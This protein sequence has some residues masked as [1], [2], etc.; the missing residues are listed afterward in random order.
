M[1]WRVNVEVLDLNRRICHQIPM[2]EPDGRKC[3]DS[4]YYEVECS[5]ERGRMTDTFET[6]F[7]VTELMCDT[8]ASGSPVQAWN[9]ADAYIL[10]KIHDDYGAALADKKLAIVN[11]QFGALTCALH[12]FNPEVYS[13]SAIF[14]RWLKI[15]RQGQDTD[16]Q[17]IESI[18]E[19]N[20]DLFLVKLPKNLHF[21]QHLLSLISGVREAVVYVSGMQKYWPKSFFQTSG[22][23]FP[24]MT[25]FPGIKKA[26]CMRLSGVQNTP[27]VDLTHLV[28]MEDFG[29]SCVNYPNVFSREQLD[30][31]A[32]FF[33]ENAPALTSAQRVMDLACGNGVLGIQALMRH[34]DCNVHFIDESDYA[35]R[36][37]E[38]SLAYNQIRAERATLHQNDCL[39]DL[40][41]H[42]FDAILCNPPFHQEHRVSSHV[43]EI[44][45]E[46]SYRALRPDGRFF[47]LANRHLQHGKQLRRFFN[48]VTQVASNSKFILYQA[49][50]G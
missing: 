31:G 15:N 2:G 3:A 10:N 38:A 22:D 18:R 47:L 32:R 27:E 49:I 46:Q 23:F 37:C 16:V 17:P 29:L 6:P 40:D 7:G 9:Q 45:I 24:E 35:M 48:K 1:A 50:K 13:D 4:L 43:A 26:K 42:D 41:L 21:F 28:Q 8:G 11:D 5:Y 44:M 12:A 14:K 20:A 33:L 19:S 34:P 30:I 39:Y 25:V 36:A